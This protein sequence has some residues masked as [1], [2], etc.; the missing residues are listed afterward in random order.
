MFGQRYHDT[1]CLTISFA[2]GEH[3]L[4]WERETT[5]LCNIFG[6]EFGWNVEKFRIPCRRHE[7]SLKA[8]RNRLRRFRDAHD[9][10][11]TLLIIYYSG[12]GVVDDGEFYFAG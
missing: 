7:E 4:E 1:H 10:Y 9:G 6:H 12:H 3:R 11:Q 8:A 2:R 5:D